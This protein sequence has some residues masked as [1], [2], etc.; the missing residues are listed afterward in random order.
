[1]LR[2]YRRLIVMQLRAQAQYRASLALDIGTYFGVT[3]LEFGVVLIVFGRFP[4]LL[5]WSLGEVVLLFAFMSLTFGMGELIGAGIDN[6]ADT[7]RRGE[8]DRVLLR[9]VGV[10]TQVLGSDFRL[11]RL[12]R[13]SQGVVTFAL[14]LRWLPDLRWTPVK[15]AML[16]LGIASGATVFLAILLLGASLCFWTVE[17]IELTS[18]LYY[19]GRELISWPIG[20]YAPSLQRIFLFV[21]PIAFGSYVPVCFILGRAL[22]FGTPAAWAFAG[23]VMA[24]L[25]A[26]LAVA[27]WRLGVAHYQSTGS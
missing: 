10:F 5:G 20:I 12:G 25:F 14:A 11:R 4:T 2:L 6:F 8:F 9:P 18:V 3:A 13:L 26:L 22:P 23:P 17:T 21:V 7:I 15:L 1:D 19:G 16:P 24:G 27:A